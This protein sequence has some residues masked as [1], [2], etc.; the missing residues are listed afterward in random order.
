MTVLRARVAV[1]RGDF[2]LDVSLSVAEGEVLAVLGPNGS[3]K[4]TLLAAIAGLI[5]LDS[6]EIALGDRTLGARTSSR[7]LH[8][9]PSRRGVGLLGQEPRLFPHL[10]AVDNVAFGAI[11]QGE[12]R[13]TARRR[14]RLWLDAVDLPGFAE[15]RPAELSGGQQQRVALARALAARPSALLLD[16]PFAA[17]DVQSSGSLRAMLRRHLAETRLPTLIVT[18]DIVDAIALADRVAIMRDGRIVDMGATSRVLDRPSDQF[19]AALLGINLL[20]GTIASGNRL[21]LDDGRALACGDSGLPVGSAASAAFPPSAVHLEPAGSPTAGAHSWSATVA[22][23]ERGVSGVLVR[24]RE[25]AIAAELSPGS[26]LHLG[27][28]PG[29]SVQVTIDPAAVSVY[30]R[31]TYAATGPESFTS[32]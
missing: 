15:R 29:S 18:H 28:A 24:V 31:S 7:R 1:R 21:L 26:L 12:R 30:P 32:R 16:E 13:S 20:H 23:L 22:A 3:G 2:R 27:L 25:H 14:A 11:A 19:G 5:A 4:S 17:L 8:L 10:R 9:A 6:G